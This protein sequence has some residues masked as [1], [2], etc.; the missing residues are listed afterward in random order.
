MYN[1]ENDFANSHNNLSVRLF[2]CVGS[3]ETDYYI[4]N[5]KKM[6]QLL[7]SHKYPN[8]KLNTHIFEGETH[9]TTGP[10]SLCRGLKILYSE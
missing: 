6:A 7:S 9:G 4:N 1:L 2:M 3:L 10:A 8:L 5:F